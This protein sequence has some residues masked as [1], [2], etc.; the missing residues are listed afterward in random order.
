MA[1]EKLTAKER[2]IAAFI[3]LEDYLQTFLRR[4]VRPELQLDKVS[5]ALEEVAT[6]RLLMMARH[7]DDAPSIRPNR[8]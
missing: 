2:E 3:A 7:Y 4:W 5:E 1:K 6:Q 8:K